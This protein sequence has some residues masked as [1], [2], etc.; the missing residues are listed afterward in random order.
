MLYVQ[1]KRYLYKCQWASRTAGRVY[2]RV[3][4]KYIVLPRAVPSHVQ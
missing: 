4:C 1:Y 3:Q 2:V